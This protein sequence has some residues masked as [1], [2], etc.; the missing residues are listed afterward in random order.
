MPH[1]ACLV[2]Q[3]MLEVMHDTVYIPVTCDYKVILTMNL[4]SFRDLNCHKIAF[5]SAVNK[6]FNINAVQ[7]CSKI[8]KN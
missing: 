6:E 4:S 3:S 8:C 1:E 7:S 5:W 2:L